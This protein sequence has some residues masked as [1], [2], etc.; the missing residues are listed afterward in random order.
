MQDQYTETL[1]LIPT[2][3]SHVFDVQLLLPSETRYIG[4]LDEA[5]EGTFTAKRGAQHF[6]RKTGSFGINLELLQRFDFK[7]IVITYCG[8]E[9]VTTREF[10]LHLGR[11]FSFVK[12]G[13]EQQCFSSASLS[14]EKS[15]RINETAETIPVPSICKTA[16]GHHH[17][18]QRNEV[19]GDFFLC[20][21]CSSAI[22]NPLLPA[23]P[24]PLRSFATKRSRNGGIAC[25]SA[26]NSYCGWSSRCGCD[27][28]LAA[29][30]VSRI[31]AGCCWS[32]IIKA[33]LTR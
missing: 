17:A 16:A 8:E 4:K 9:L 6:Y 27:I 15:K 30:T 7:W 14:A 21:H 10:M 11:V 19:R 26:F 28:E 18:P 20:A 13:F 24:I 3:F 2:K 29:T 5:G 1:R 22:R 23:W 25:G 12:A 33:F 31:K 32:S